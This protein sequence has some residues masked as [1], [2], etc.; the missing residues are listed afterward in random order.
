MSDISKS[1]DKAQSGVEKERLEKQQVEAQLLS[2]KKEVECLQ[3]ELTH[4][5]LRSEKKVIGF[6]PKV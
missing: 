4:L 3:Q 5:C 2:T 6:F 1:L